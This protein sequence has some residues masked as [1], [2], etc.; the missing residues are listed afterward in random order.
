[1]YAEMTNSNGPNN[2]KATTG[3][4]RPKERTYPIATEESTQKIPLILEFLAQKG[5][6]VKNTKTESVEPTKKK[7]SQ[8]QISTSEENGGFLSRFLVK[9]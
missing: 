1:M 5:L 9:E 7:K 4:R 8:P 2:D 3:L 6:Q